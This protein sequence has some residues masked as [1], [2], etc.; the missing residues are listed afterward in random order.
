M[1]TLV[2]T[3]AW[4]LIALAGALGTLCRYGLGRLVGKMTHGNFPWGTFVVNA[5][6]CL[7]IGVIAGALARGATMSPAL[8]V[9]IMVGFLGGFTTFSAFSLETFALGSGREW[10]AAGGY[11]MLTNVVALAA[12]WVGHRLLV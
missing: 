1:T 3:H 2:P 9:A 4:F 8:R 10:F 7:A 12:V 6:G 11:V 5:L